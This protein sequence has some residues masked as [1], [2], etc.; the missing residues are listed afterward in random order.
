MCN[1]H[2]LENIKYLIIKSIKYDSFNSFLLFIKKND[3]IS[4]KYIELVIESVISDKKSYDYLQILLNTKIDVNIPNKFNYT[5]IFL[6]IFEAKPKCA[7]L[8]ID[9]KANINYR[10]NFKNTPLIQCAIRPFSGC[11]ELLVNANSDINAQNINN[12]T[13]FHYFIENDDYYGIQI[14]IDAKAKINIKDYMNNTALYIIEKNASKYDNQCFDKRIK[15]IIL[16]LHK[17]NKKRKFIDSQLDDCSICLDKI[18][19]I[20]KN[21]YITK[22]YHIFHINCWTQYNKKICPICREIC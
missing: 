11:L 12:K 8:L 15:D 9:Y 2:P 6:T 22:C 13:A 1:I 3:K 19:N 4:Y 18:G 7:K 5:P 20:K 14:L 10:D 21:L 17:N 16:N